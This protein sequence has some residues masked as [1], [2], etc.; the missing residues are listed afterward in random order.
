MSE[1]LELT[2]EAADEATDKTAADA[3]P[4]AK[5]PNPRAQIEAAAKQAGWA[6]PI[7]DWK[8]APEDYLDAPEFI[9]KAA[10]EV[11]PSMRKTLNESKAE[12]AK[13]SKALKEFGEHHSKT[14]AKAYERALKDLEARQDLAVEAGD[15]QAA[16]AI[17][18]EITDLATEAVKPPVAETPSDSDELTAWKA[19]N[20]W[21]TKD[22]AMRGA[23]MEIANEVEQTTGMKSG[24]AFFA[25]VDKRI[26]AAF[27]DK[28]KNPRRE[29]AGTVE[30]TSL[31]RRQGGKTWSDLTAEQKE[32]ADFFVKT[33][34][35]FTRE[36]YVKD[37]FGATR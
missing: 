12:I 17:T 36:Q 15:V 28:F 1:P 7:A 26:R 30:A 31:G 13:L 8:G 3:A 20:P 33:V 25:E 19:E 21:F 10:G 6:G 24:P 29:E 23:T 34:K 9:L 11:L 16:R 22:A 37:T 4:E 2:A 14:E 35:G 18:K 32:M 27:P 5:E